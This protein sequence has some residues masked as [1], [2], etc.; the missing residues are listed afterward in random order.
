MKENL[1]R[2][3]LEAKQENNDNYTNYLL[4]DQGIVYSTCIAAICDL[5]DDFAIL[6]DEF[7]ADHTINSLETPYGKVEKEMEDNGFLWVW[8]TEEDAAEMDYYLNH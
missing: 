3:M 5:D 8:F 1:V 4:V 7:D 6:M 2:T